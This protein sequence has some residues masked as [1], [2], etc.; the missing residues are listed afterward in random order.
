[1]MLER[2]E[3]LAVRAADGL[4]TPEELQELLAAGVDVDEMARVRSVVREA[5]WPGA[6]PELAGPVLRAVGLDDGYRRGAV[7]AALLA[8]RGGTPELSA[9]VLGAAALDEVDTGPALRAALDAGA[10][11]ELGD[12]VLEGAGLEDVAIGRA[13]REAL[14]AG[15]TPE[16]ADDTLAATGQ[17]D[18]D[19]DIGAMLRDALGGPAPDLS[20]DVLAA[21]GATEP[22]YGA[23]L[24]AGMGEAPDLAGDVL[25]AIGADAEEDLIAA[26]L[27]EGAGAAPDLWSAIAAEVGVPEAAPG[28]PEPALAEVVPLAP[29][30]RWW[31][32]AAGLAAAAAA[33]V[34]LVVGLPGER[35]SNL[36]P[37]VA[38]HIHI[39][40]VNEV[41][42]EEIAVAP[43]ANVQVLQFEEGA[44]TIIFIEDIEDS[45]GVDDAEGVPL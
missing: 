32:P 20:R 14:Y 39:E 15:P 22:D 17:A 11:P 16:L 43:D 31:L 27:V 4:A 8:G 35:D 29:R 36:H 18:L 30:R 34:L 28:A 13:V 38:S 12:D 19:L 44:P 37:A 25:A 3:G 1:M 23:L 40:A 24:R 9:A 45:D 41:E 21:I 5:L 10:A 42:I 7:A 33:A 6:A 2:I 26:A